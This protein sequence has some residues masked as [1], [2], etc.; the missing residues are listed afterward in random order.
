[1]GQDQASAPRVSEL[2][3]LSALSQLITVLWAGE[4][5]FTLVSDI[6][7]L[8]FLLSFFELTYVKLLSKQLQVH[9]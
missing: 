2:L 3:C 5:Q 8:H 6:P 1:M 9:M 4:C 7:S